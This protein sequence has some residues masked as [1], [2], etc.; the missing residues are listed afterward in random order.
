MF[1]AN[2]AVRVGDVSDGTSHTLC[3]GE[4]TGAR[5]SSGGVPAFFQHFIMT[6]NIQNT[7]D[8]INSWRTVPGGRDDSPTGDPI[9]GDGGNRHY[10]L[11]EEIG[12]SSFH[13][14]GCNFL[15]VDGSVHFLAETIAQPTLT[16]LTTRAGMEPVGTGLR[17]NRRR[18]GDSPQ[19]ARMNGG[20]APCVGRSSSYSA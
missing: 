14:G 1:F 13:P 11:F 19:I 10:E 9:D 20:T 6:Q 8:G 2:S 18:E 15:M 16:A 5:G 4:I 3:V 17:V 7:H 12:F